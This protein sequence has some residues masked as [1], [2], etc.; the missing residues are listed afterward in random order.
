MPGCILP[1][2]PFA[3]KKYCWSKNKFLVQKQRLKW[4]V[5]VLYLFFLSEAAAHDLNWLSGILYVLP[6]LSAHLLQHTRAG[7][8]LRCE[9]QKKL[10][11]YICTIWVASPIEI[12]LLETDQLGA[13]RRVSFWLRQLRSFCLTH[14]A[15]MSPTDY[16]WNFLFHLK[17]IFYLNFCL[18]IAWFISWWAISSFLNYSS[19]M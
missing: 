15:I 13:A 12:D 4:N 8:G 2:K 14:T 9:K 11:I 3:L 19:M 18:F 5:E 7:G 6:T 17:N 10:R 1:E 16:S